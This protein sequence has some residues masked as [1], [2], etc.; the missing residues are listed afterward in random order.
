MTITLSNDRGWLERMAKKE[1]YGAVSTGGL[2]ARML[3]EG[4]MQTFE[5]GPKVLGR[6]IELARRQ[7]GLT[8]PKLAEK[9]DIDLA[10]ALAI[11]LNAW[12]DP[13]PRAL[14][15]LAKALSLPPFAVMELAGLVQRRDNKLADAAVRFA[16]KAEPTA[17]LSREEKEALEEFVRV[18]A[19][20]SD[21][22]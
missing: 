19:E 20:L 18:L 21:R 6:L 8:V 4:Q 15:G 16:A 1:T 11:E 7:K 5:G 2:F 13:Q 17:E 14:F 3:S 9:A 22:R 10:E 12:R